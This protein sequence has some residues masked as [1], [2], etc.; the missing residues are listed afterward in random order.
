MAAIALA[1]PAVTPSA[2]VAAS[3]NAIVGIG[4]VRICYDGGRRDADGYTGRD[5]RCPPP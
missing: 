1:Q 4:T 2:P 5:A 3:V